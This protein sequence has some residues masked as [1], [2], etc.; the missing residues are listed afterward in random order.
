MLFPVIRP[1]RYGIKEHQFK[2]LSPARTIPYR[3]ATI[4]KVDGQSE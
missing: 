4:G 1:R 3:C 2:R